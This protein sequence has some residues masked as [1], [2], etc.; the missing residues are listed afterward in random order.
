M[1]VIIRNGIEYSGSCETA[2]AINYDN[3]HSGLNA[4][5]VQEGIDELSES[6]SIETTT[7]NASNPKIL[8]Q[9]M[10]R[11]RQLLINTGTQKTEKGGLIGTIPEGH[12]PLDPIR[13]TICN[14]TADSAIVLNADTGEITA[15]REVPAYSVASV[16]YFC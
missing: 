1:G 15:L 7:A 14:S 5:T 11:I 16:F 10:G 13:A 6:L 3:S 12:I 4:K 9:K 2:T 8:I